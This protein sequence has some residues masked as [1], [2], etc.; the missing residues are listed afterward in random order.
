[1]RVS[2]KITKLRLETCRAFA[3]NCVG[4]EPPAGLPE[5]KEDGLCRF[6]K[7]LDNTPPSW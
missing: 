7:R 4:A 3:K 6:D 1:M 2:L 5:I